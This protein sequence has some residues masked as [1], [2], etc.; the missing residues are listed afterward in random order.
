MW[1]QKLGLE[2]TYRRLINVFERAGFQNYAEIVRSIV[3]EEESEIEDSSDYDEPIPQPETYPKVQLNPPQAP[4]LSRYV[5]SY[6]E[7]ILINPATH[8][9]NLPKGEYSTDNNNSNVKGS[10]SKWANPQILT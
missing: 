8:A 7:Y 5:S 4:K 3:C 6:D 10:E 9:N 1:K 2:A